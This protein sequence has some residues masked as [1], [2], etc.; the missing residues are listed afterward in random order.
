MDNFDHVLG[1]GQSLVGTTEI[2]SQSWIGPVT[3]GGN[4]IL[5]VFLERG[6]CLSNRQNSITLGQG[7]LFTKATKIQ[8]QTLDKANHYLDKSGKFQSRLVLG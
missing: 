4:Q 3:C 7:Q 2:Q 6:N 8:L 5:V 1:Q